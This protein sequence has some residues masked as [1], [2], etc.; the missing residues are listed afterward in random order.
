L[1]EL[2][3]PNLVIQNI[4][5]LEL[6]CFVEWHQ[7]KLLSSG[8]CFYALLLPL[9]VFC[10]ASCGIESLQILFIVWL[11]QPLLSFEGSNS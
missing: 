1:S 7:V 9:G 8:L 11:K 5:Y 4:P 2:V 3:E 10:F 6:N